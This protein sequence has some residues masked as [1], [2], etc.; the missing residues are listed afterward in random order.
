MY[1]GDLG[2]R[3]RKEDWQQMLARVPA[4]KKYIYERMNERTNKWNKTKSYVFRPLCYLNCYL[5]PHLTSNPFSNF[6]SLAFIN[7]PNLTSLLTHTDTILVW[8]ARP[9]Q[10]G[11]CNSLLTGPLLS[12]L[13]PTIYCP[14]SSKRVPQNWSLHCSK[15]SKDFQCRSKWNRK[16]FQWPIRPAASTPPPSSSSTSFTPFWPC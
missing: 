7:N 6:V 13:L 8:A 16:S 4:L 2:R 1:W 14:L 12:F 3:R 10:L 5:S 11:N 15:T 9:A